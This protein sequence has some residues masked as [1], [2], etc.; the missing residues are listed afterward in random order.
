MMH[1]WESATM[2]NW[3]VKNKIG[4]AFMHFYQIIFMKWRSKM[5]IAE[6]REESK[7]HNNSNNNDNSDDVMS[8]NSTNADCIM[9]RGEQDKV[10][11]RMTMKHAC[12]VWRNFWDNIKEAWKECVEYL[13]SRDILGKFIA[14]PVV[15]V[16]PAITMDRLTIKWSKLCSILWTSM[17]FNRRQKETTTNIICFGKERVTKHTSN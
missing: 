14:L 16:P 8:I 3:T 2:E 10:R 1:H 15:V 7:E 4:Q 17:L 6:Q 13:N 9:E 11:H 5:S 12:S